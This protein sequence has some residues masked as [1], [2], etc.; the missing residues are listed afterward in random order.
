MESPDPFTDAH[1]AIREAARLLRTARHGV[2]FTGA[3]I[4]TESGIPD[5]RGPQGIWKR[6][7]PIEYQEFLSSP[8]AR[9][10]YWRRKVEMYPALRDAR[11]NAGH[12]ALARLYA[13]GLLRSIITQ[14][15]DGLHQKA[16]VPAERVIE[17]HGS[18]AHIVCIRCGKRYDWG[19]ILAR[20]DGDCPTCDSC[21]G[22]LKPATISF[23]QAMPEQET[24]QA[25]EEAAA[26]D[27]LLVVGSSLRVYPAASIPIETCRAGGRMVIVNNEPTAQDESAVLVLHGQAGQILQAIAD[28]AIG[29]IASSIPEAEEE[30]HA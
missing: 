17:I 29:P 26:A 14:N 22:W 18:E 20:F 11:P 2:A 15:I 7:R 24:R 6:Y 4:S 28:R 16:G 30:R 23:G 8:E 21:R 12:L 3:G 9:R 27:L 10:E 13:A 5:F 25:F 1:E 19:E